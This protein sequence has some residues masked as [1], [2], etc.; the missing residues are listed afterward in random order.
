[1]PI[2]PLHISDF[3]REYKCSFIQ[4]P[5]A[6]RLQFFSCSL[7]CTEVSV[8][9]S[10][11]IF[12]KTCYQNKEAR[13]LFFSK[14][15]LK[16]VART[17]RQ[18]QENVVCGFGTCRRQLLPPWAPGWPLCWAR[19]VQR[20]CCSKT[21]MTTHSITVRCWL[22]LINKIGIFRKTFLLFN[23]QMKFKVWASLRDSVA[24]FFASGFQSR[25]TVP[26]ILWSI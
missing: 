23:F 21:H 13:V 6:M 26:L 19:R 25:G 15:I 11:H 2:L 14:A 5:A 8:Q 4:F 10:V 16:P 18:L 12:K 9:D 22:R 24:R 3:T 7:H 20:T 17:H 1:M